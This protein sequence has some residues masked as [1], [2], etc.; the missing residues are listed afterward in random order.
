MSNKEV[1]FEYRGT[2]TYDT[3]DPLLDKLKVQSGF[4]K[5]KRGIQKRLYS[6]FVECI[7]NIYKYEANDLDH[8]NNKKHYISLGKLDDQFIISTGNIIANERIQGLQSRLERINRQDHIE[9]MTSYS[10]IIDKD[11]ISNEEGAG[12]GLITIAL[13]SHNKINYTF[14]TID[15]YHSYFEM[16]VLIA[17]NGGD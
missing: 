17:N 5:L 6:V 12:L 1:I 9:L 14:T 3:I 8:V 4:R 13:Q 15:Q 11:I 2:V 10:E 16:N 7:E